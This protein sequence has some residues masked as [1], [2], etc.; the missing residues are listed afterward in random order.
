M[1]TI[2]P[3]YESRYSVFHELMKFRVREILLVSSLYDAF[4]LEE[5]GR[6]SDRL[7]TEYVELN[8]RFIPRITRVSSAEEALNILSRQSFDLVITM[9]RLTDMDPLE[10]GR[11]VK[12]FDPSK[13]VILLSI[14]PVTRSLLHRARQ[15]QSIDKVFYWSGDSRIL[16]AIVKYVEDLKNITTDTHR[17]VQVILVI[18]DSPS[19]SSVF[20]PMLYTEIMTQTRHL[21]SD[22]VNDTHRLLRMRARPKILLAETFEDGLRFFETYK[23]NLLG[24][25]SDIRFPHHDR[26]DPGAGFVFAEMAKAEV[27]DLPIL[28]QSMEEENLETA[29]QRGFGYLNKSSDHLLLGLQQ[30]IMKNCGFGDFVFR[31]PNG[32]EIGRASNL[33]EL[34]EQ[35]QQVDGSSLEFHARRNHISI[36]LRARTEFELAEILRPKKVSDFTST[37]ELRRNVCEAIARAIDQEQSGII[38]DFKAMQVSRRRAFIRIGTG[39]LGGKARG[40]AFINALIAHHTLFDKYDSVEIKIPNTFV[41]CSEVFEEFVEAGQLQ[42]IA[43]D[44][45][46]D[47]ELTRLFRNAYLPPG[48][49]DDLRA[50]LREID[51]PLAV[52]SSSFLEDSQVLPFAGIYKTFMLPNN[53]PDLDVRLKQLTDAIKLVYASI[54]FQSPKEYVKN[55]NYRIEDEKMAVI[56]QELAGIRHD[57]IVYPTFSGVACSYN[58]YP[59]SYLKPDQGIV[60]L[61]LGL[62]CYIVEGGKT[63]QFSPAHPKKNPPYGSPLDL[64]KNTQTE[65]YALGMQKPDIR[66]SDDEAFSLIKLGLDRA[67]RDGSL[68]HIAS[69]LSAQDNA[70]RDT[71][72]LPGP[73]VLTFA[74]I[75]KYNQLPLA[76]IVSELLEIGRNAFGM[77]VEIEFAVNMNPNAGEKNE[78][79]FLQIRPMGSGEKH[80]EVTVD[81]AASESFCM[82]QKTMGNGVFTGIHDIVYLDPDTFDISKSWKIAGEIGEIN[83]QLQDENR[84]C[85]LIGFGR[86]A[87]ADPW[88]GIPVKWHQISRTRVFVEANTDSL[89]VDPSQGSHFFQNMLSLGLGYF[90]I[91]RNRD[92]EFVNWDWLKSQPL[93]CRTHFVRH[94]RLEQPVVVKLDGRTSRGVMLKP[95]NNLNHTGE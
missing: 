18:E 39:S 54:F 95:T 80:P 1:S 24:I 93:H 37:D 35:L 2:S 63:Y 91:Q 89:Q 56:I 13:P 76:P 19:F 9:A 62:G 57:E 82:S 43:I 8:L 46:S 68:T 78:F 64:A 90:F 65:F 28:L 83:R 36:W 58:F 70:I 11:K 87:T 84:F 30:F 92:E 61:A 72:T 23:K 3:E 88:L 86:W 14:E 75:L 69:T 47:E 7:F 52:R 71:L 27:P 66:V 25:I 34:L 4:V 94:V 50:I 81:E 20:L 60:S 21:I 67:E 5:D 38:R 32:N 17:G 49:E 31:L 45:D 16:L 77:P 40:I 48:I 33:Q 74:N 41:L 51:Y 85:I 6:L 53:H 12:D 55:S 79:F 42:R 15:E 10:F 73:R 44:S 26:M 29:R 59:F 22:S